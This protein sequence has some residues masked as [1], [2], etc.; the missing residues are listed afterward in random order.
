[1]SIGKGVCRVDCLP[2]HT[3]ILYIALKTL[4]EKE[5]GGGRGGGSVSFLLS[6]KASK[7]TGRVPSRRVHAVIIMG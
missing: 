5:V 7:L 2:A 4:G 6:G 1:M 3:P